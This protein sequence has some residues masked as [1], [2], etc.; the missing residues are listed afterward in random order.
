MYTDKNGKTVHLFDFLF[1][2]THPNNPD[3]VQY[4][5]ITFA[6]GQKAGQAAKRNAIAWAVERELETG[7]YYRLQKSGPAGS[8][9]EDFANGIAISFGIPL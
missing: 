9:D 5:L 1:R 4:T 8:L 7:C 2:V 6:D 3:H